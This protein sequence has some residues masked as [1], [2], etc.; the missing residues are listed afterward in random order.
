[1]RFLFPVFL[2]EKSPN[3]R[4]KVFSQNFLFLVISTLFVF[5]LFFILNLFNMS[6]YISLLICYFDYLNITTNN[7]QLKRS[8]R[9]NKWALRFIINEVLSLSTV[10]F[11]L[12]SIY[13]Y[14]F[15]HT[16]NNILFS[17]DKS[18]N[19]GRYSLNVQI[20]QFFFQKI[21]FLIQEIKIKILIT[22]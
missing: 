10:S 14:I 12:F 6:L 2:F 8:N 16:I 5:W 7:H 3:P 13:L 1:M 20:K 9:N 22:L 21:F 11:F 4:A 17:F 19:F 18:T 15:I